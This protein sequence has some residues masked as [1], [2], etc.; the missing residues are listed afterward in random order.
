[1]QLKSSSVVPEYN[2][3]IIQSA[4]FEGSWNSQNVLINQHSGPA[5][6]QVLCLTRCLQSVQLYQR[7]TACSEEDN[8]RERSEGEA[9]W[10]KKRFAERHERIVAESRWLQFWLRRNKCTSEAK[11]MDKGKFEEEEDKK[12]SINGLKTNKQKTYGSNW[13]SFLRYEYCPNR[14]AERKW[15]RWKEYLL[16]HGE[17]GITGM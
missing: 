8:R 17:C 5:H 13:L 16:S 9:K 10:E 2:E 3:V 14:L 6:H 12:K 7:E 11:T 4:D 15:E 1:M